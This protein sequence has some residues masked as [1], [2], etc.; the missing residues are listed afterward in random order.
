[1]ITQTPPCSIIAITFTPIHNSPVSRSPHHL[2][3]TIPARET[4]P[5]AGRLSHMHTY[6]YIPSPRHLNTI[7]TACPKIANPGRVAH[8]SKRPFSCS[9]TTAPV[10]ATLLISLA[11][12][13]HP[14]SHDQPPIW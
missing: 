8:L 4:V 9:L 3:A 13:R 7:F 10:L 6:I 1:M 5:I 2:L 14:F 11:A 12:E